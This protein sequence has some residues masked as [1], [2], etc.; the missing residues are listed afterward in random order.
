MERKVGKRSFIRS[1][2]TALIIAGAVCFGLLVAADMLIRPTLE[3]LLEYKC[4]T[5]AERIISDAVFDNFSDGDTGEIVSFTF[6]KDGRIAA[7]TTDRARIN[8]LKAKLNEAVNEGIERL[9][10]ETVRI[11]V[12]T[13]TGLSFL[14]GT[15]DEIVFRIESRGK[16]ET[17]LRSSFRSAGINQTVHSII[18]DVNVTLCPM[19]TGFSETFGIDCDILLAQTVIVGEVP[20]SYSNIVID[21]EN[22]DNLADIML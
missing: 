14:Y 11:S 17:H 5:S 22:T 1:L 2:G 15:G 7:L 6:D 12:G 18:L 9:A 13:L 8:S 20:D 4:R 10:N 16:A 3:T 21:G 19:T